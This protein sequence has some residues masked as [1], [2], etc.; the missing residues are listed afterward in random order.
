VFDIF[1]SVVDWRSS[2]IAEGMAWGKAK[3]LNISWAEFA[4]RWRLGYQPAMD[5]V[6]NGTL[7][8]T[9][10]DDLHRMILEDL[11]TEFKIEALSEDEKVSWTHVWRRLNPI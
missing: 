4:D 1:G 11:L 2:V 5:K 3:G 9:R 6:R 10:L 8:W 7:P